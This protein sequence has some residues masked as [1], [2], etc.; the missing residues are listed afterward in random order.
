LS[1]TEQR[2][3]T[4]MFQ[5]LQRMAKDTRGATAVEYGF[6]LAMIVLAMMTALRGVASETSALWEEVSSK[7]AEATGN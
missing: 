5:L 6:I 7:T 2:D 3:A 4:G 1:S